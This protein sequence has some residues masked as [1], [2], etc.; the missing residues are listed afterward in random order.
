MNKLIIQITI[1]IIGL[2]STSIAIWTLLHTPTLILPPLFLIGLY[3]PIVFV[4]SL[5]IGF[6]IKKLLKSSWHTLTFTS[7]I[8]SVICLSFYASQYKLSYEIIVPNNY[9]GEVKLILSNEKE[10]DFKINNYGIGYIS[11]TTYE[12]GFQPTIIKNG[13][14]ITKEINGYMTNSHS[15]IDLS[16]DYMSFEIPGKI[17]STSYYNDF[18]TLKK[19]RAI[20]T[21]RLK[22]R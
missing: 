17:D 7:L 5:V 18:D 2:I 4:F 13:E 20:D 21:S 22:R 6:L 19:Y 15:G 9:V 1:G 12:N 16:V 11:Q 10:N 14:D 8:L 3:L